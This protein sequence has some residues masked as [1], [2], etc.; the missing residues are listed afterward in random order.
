MLTVIPDFAKPAVLQYFHKNMYEM[1]KDDKYLGGRGLSEW[2]THKELQKLEGSKSLGDIGNYLLINQ[3]I[4]KAVHEKDWI[5]TVEIWSHIL[6]DKKDAPNDKS[7]IWNELGWHTNYDD[8]SDRTDTILPQLSFVYYIKCEEDKGGYLEISEK[9]IH[10][11]ISD[12]FGEVE[13]IKTETN[14]LVIFNSMHWHRVVD[15]HGYRYSINMDLWN[16]EDI[17]KNRR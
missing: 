12:G 5:K 2:Y 7:K 17:L 9:T 8:T 4:K 15:V 11:D 6:M 16:N 13:R 14:K 1:F 3:K 10:D